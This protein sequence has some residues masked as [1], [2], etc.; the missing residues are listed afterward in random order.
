M[1]TLR[2]LT[3]A[4]PT[5]ID[6]ELF[7]LLARRWTLTE[8]IHSLRIG[9]AATLWPDAARRY[10]KTYRLSPAQWNDFYARSV[11]AAAELVPVDARIG[12]LS[13]EYERRGGWSRYQLVASRSAKAGHLHRPHCHT[14]RMTTK[15]LWVP[16]ASALGAADVVGRF[17]ETACS[18]C[19][20]DAPVAKVA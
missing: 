10:G 18:H 14:L 16:E 1:Q 6:T 7:E 12:E 13:A 9:I 17:G 15:V 4:S 8:R 3:A 19:F 11:A 2:D 5:D 20:P